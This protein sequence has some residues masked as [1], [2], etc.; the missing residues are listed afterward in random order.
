M[1]RELY[2]VG[3]RIGKEA[4][5]RTSEDVIAG[6]A[7]HGKGSLAGEIRSFARILS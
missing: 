5:W 4:D 3:F 7:D 6:N 1:L 2:E